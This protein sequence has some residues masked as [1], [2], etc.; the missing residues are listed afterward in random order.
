MQILFCSECGIS[1]D[2]KYRYCQNCGKEFTMKK[3]EDNTVNIPR[4]EKFS[5]KERINAYK[6]INNLLLIVK[7][8]GIVL[9][10]LFIILLIY[11]LSESFF[12]LLFLIVFGAIVFVLFYWIL[13]GIKERDNIVRVVLI[14]GSIILIITSLT[15]LPIGYIGIAIGTYFLITLNNKD[16][17]RV[18]Q[19]R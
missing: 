12:L 3:I 17:K 2:D 19:Y 14:V 6:S 15:F 4:R 10:G 7:Y 5:K 8:L 11:S 13:N 9:I 1:R 18:F 16:V